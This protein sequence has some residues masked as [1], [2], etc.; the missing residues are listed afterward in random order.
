MLIDEMIKYHIAGNS[1][2]TRYKHIWI[3][4]LTWQRDYRVKI[5]KKAYNTLI[6]NSR[7]FN[8][9]PDFPAWSFLRPPKFQQI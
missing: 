6:Y 4:L 9:R 7:F 1:P 2:F 5:E 3:F 8:G